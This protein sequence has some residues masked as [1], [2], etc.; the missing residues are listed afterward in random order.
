MLG[1]GGTPVEWIEDWAR[2]SD[3]APGV[4]VAALVAMLR[5]ARVGQLAE[6]FWQELLER[7]ELTPSELDV[8]GA[9]RAAGRPYTLRPSQLY[10]PL[11]RSSGGM[12]K[13]LA[14]LE[15]RGLV[16]RMPNP[17]DG[18]SRP[19]VLSARGVA[20]HDRVLR[21]SAA[22][23]AGLLGGMAEDERAG[24]GETLP[25]L[26]EQLEAPAAD[27]A[28]APADRPPD[29]GGSRPVRRRGRGSRGGPT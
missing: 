4:D 15:A 22:A 2:A 23:A 5:L 25:R 26:L 13:I 21:G 14:R 20:L 24:L 12:T 7:Y 10:A 3:E 28:G 6:A 16:T 27:A 29:R 9:L 18:R 1:A 17:E 8:L 11:R 19:V